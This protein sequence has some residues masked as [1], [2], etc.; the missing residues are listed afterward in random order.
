MM[1]R[2]EL[3]LRVTGK[4]WSRRGIGLLEMLMAAFA[5]GVLSLAALKFYQS[6]HSQMLQQNEVMDVQQNLRAVMNELTRQVR[7]AGYMAQGTVPVQAA[8]TL[9]DMLVVRYHDGDSVRSQIFFLLSD[10]TGQSNLMTQLNGEAPQLFAEGIDS[11][12]FI[13]GGA[14]GSVDWVRVNL[15]ARS[16]SAGF[17]TG[18]GTTE[19]QPHLYRRLTS[20]IK[21]RNNDDL[22]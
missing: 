4:L 1:I 15:V 2:H 13:T 3:R 16:A 7:Q 17:R 5:V 18:S 9:N 22:Y 19:Q 20:T 12:R 21:L 11:A 10:S 14:G 8:G 6:Q